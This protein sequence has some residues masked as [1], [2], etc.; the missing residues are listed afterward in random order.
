VLD[1]IRG[2]PALLL[3]GLVPAVVAVLS[4]VILRLDPNIAGPLIIA[5]TAAGAWLTRQLVT[6]TA[7]A[8]IPA[9][10]GVTTPLGP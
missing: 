7:S 1:V 9:A 4:T 8:P 3:A 5:V 10:A 6:P 2:E